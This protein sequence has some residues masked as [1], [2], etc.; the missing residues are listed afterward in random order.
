MGCGFEPG[1]CPKNAAL[2][3]TLCFWHDGL[4]QIRNI[5]KP[6][7]ALSGSVLVPTHF[8][9]NK[10]LSMM[11]MPLNRVISHKGIFW[12]T[13]VLCVPTRGLEIGPRFWGRHRGQPIKWSQDNGGRE[14]PFPLPLRSCLKKPRQD[15]VAPKA[16]ITQWFR[17]RTN[18]KFWSKRTILNKKE[19]FWTKRDNLEPK[20]TVL[21]KKGQFRATRD[22]LEP[23]GII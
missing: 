18:F 16:D 5:A 9:V 15:T 12:A 6:T 4:F 20:G 1:R 14:L 11:C 8:W 13:L 2:E 3:K 17:W 22:N 21:Y 10:S 19:Q 23:K 7:S